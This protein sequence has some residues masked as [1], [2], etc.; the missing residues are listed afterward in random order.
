M[1]HI[2]PAQRA[3]MQN[4]YSV[5]KHRATRLRLPF[6][7][8]TF[9]SWIEEI[10]RLAPLGADVTQA[11][12][13]YDIDGGISL[14]W[15]EKPVVK[16]LRKVDKGL[17]ASPVDTKVLFAVELMQRIMTPGPEELREKIMAAAEVAGIDLQE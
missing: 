8:P 17:K 7:W 10:M 1:A 13:V 9:R 12:V 4:R 3:L 14:R 11:A 6:P 2:T 5:A 15:G 16:K